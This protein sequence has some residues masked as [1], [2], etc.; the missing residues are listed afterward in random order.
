MQA[1]STRKAYTFTMMKVAL[2]A[3]TLLG[4]LTSTS[5]NCCGGEITLHLMPQNL[6]LIFIFIFLLSLDAY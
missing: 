5:A 6:C 2:A 3:L 4:L 1:V